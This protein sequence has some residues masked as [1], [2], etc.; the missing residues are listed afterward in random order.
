MLLC[1]IS[2]VAQS[3]SRVCLLLPGGD[4]RSFCEQLLIDCPET[5]AWA[6]E[7]HLRR[8]ICDLLCALHLLV[9]EIREETLHL[10]IAVTPDTGAAVASERQ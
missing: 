1:F 4:L 5:Q 6:N 2:Y 8:H 7:L 10:R 3:Q 9:Q